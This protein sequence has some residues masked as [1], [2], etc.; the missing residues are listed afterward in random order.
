MKPLRIKIPGTVA[1]DRNLLDD[2]LRIEGHR[3]ERDAA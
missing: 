1:S 3:V 2:D